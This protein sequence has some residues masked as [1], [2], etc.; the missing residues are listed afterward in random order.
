MVYGVRVLV[1]LKSGVEI[2]KSSGDGTKN[3]PYK[4]VQNEILNKSKVVITCFLLL[5]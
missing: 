4:L 2:D 3:S 5:V 1:T